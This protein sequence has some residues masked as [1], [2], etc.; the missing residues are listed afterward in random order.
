MMVATVSSSPQVATLRVITCLTG[1]V[2]ASALGNR[3]HNVALGQYAGEAPAR[4]AD[5]HRAD[6]ARSEQAR[7]R[8][9]I[10]RRFDAD[11]LAALGGQNCGRYAATALLNATLQAG[12]LARRNIVGVRLLRRRIEPGK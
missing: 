4:A 3:A 2:S 11:N 1:S 10:R 8:C 6:P 5:D 9:R 12:L 7:R